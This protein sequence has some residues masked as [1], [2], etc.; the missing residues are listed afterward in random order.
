M[1]ASVKLELH[2]GPERSR[3]V[4][5]RL[6]FS[7][8]RVFFWVGVAVLFPV[9]F[10]LLKNPSYDRRRFKPETICWNNLRQLDRA[11]ESV[12][13]E[14][15]IS[16]NAVVPADRIIAVLPHKTIPKCPKGGRYSFGIAGQ[17]PTCSVHSASIR[18]KLGTNSP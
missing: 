2:K 7:A 16:T 10:V 1:V 9:V 3:I 12:A 5:W 11:T 13:L 17:E 8:R 15:G 14:Q 6:Q 4:D 18:A